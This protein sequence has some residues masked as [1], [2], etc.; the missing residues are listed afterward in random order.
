MHLY[1]LGLKLNHQGMVWENNVGMKPYFNGCTFLGGEYRLD[2]LLDV[3]DCTFTS[4]DFESTSPTE[5][6]QQVR[7]ARFNPDE[8][9]LEALIALH[10]GVAM[11]C[12]SR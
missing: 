3:Y 10:V 12:L 7:S 4:Q 11:D 8:A 6:F 9:A 1:S 2:E 5:R